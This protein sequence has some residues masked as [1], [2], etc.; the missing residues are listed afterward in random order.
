MIQSTP[1]VEGVV[2][3]QR[4]D[5]ITLAHQG[6]G[7]VRANETVCTGDEN[8]LN[9]CHLFDLIDCLGKTH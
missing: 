7:E 3:N 2:H 1:R 9:G 5:F 8:F 4:F 6:F